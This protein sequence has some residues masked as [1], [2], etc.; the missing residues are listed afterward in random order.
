MPQLSPIKWFILYLITLIIIFLLLI[1]MNFI[2]FYFNLF[3]EPKMKQMFT[4]KLL[5]WKF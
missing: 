1:K 4:T 2:H 3:N 5:K